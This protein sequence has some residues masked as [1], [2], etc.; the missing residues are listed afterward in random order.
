MIKPEQAMGN[1]KEI[2]SREPPPT[3]YH[4]TTQQGLLGIIRDKEIWASHTQYLN[5]VR[6]FR[7]ALDIFKEELSAMKSEPGRD[8]QAAKCLSAMEVVISLGMESV[9][10]CLCSFSERGDV[11]SQWRAYGGATSGFAIGFSGTA[12]RGMS[13]R[14]GWLVPAIYDQDQQR[15]LVRTLLQDVLAE[16][17]KKLGDHRAE[18]PDINIKNLLEYIPRYAPILKHHSFVEEYEWRIVTKPLMCTSERFGYRP[19]SSM[20]IPYY[21]LPLV[22]E[23]HYGIK[24]IVIGPTPHP[25]QSLRAVTG[26][27]I[28]YGMST[29][30]V[31]SPNT[32]TVRCSESPY[33]SW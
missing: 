26:L 6:E 1:A 2:L 31:A 11:L 27:L 18:Q 14:H 9:N 3:L 20:L 24:E 15:S 16:D 33:R 13:E 12:L 32:V 22:H 25:E 10:V 19:G 29:S 8:E 5:D 28:K 21:R 7:H 17:M 4:Y 23:K 30:T